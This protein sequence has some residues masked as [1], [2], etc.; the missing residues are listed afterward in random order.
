M[1]IAYKPLVSQPPTFGESINVMVKSIASD[2]W[3]ATFIC[4]IED[5]VMIKLRQSR[6][7]DKRLKCFSRIL[8]LPTI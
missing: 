6:P 7:S 1:T 3:R 2:W 8:Q 5:H 4:Q